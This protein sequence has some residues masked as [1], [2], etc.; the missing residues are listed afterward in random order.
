MVRGL[1]VQ[2]K[3]AHKFQHVGATVWELRNCRCNVVKPQ[4]T[5]ALIETAQG[6]V[7]KGTVQLHTP[8]QPWK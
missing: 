6:E 1:L 2:P 5:V 3:W 4:E 8:A 7:L